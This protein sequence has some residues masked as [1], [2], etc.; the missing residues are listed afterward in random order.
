MPSPKLV[1]APDAVVAPVPPPRIETVPES[2]IVPELV[3]GPFSKTRPATVE[4]MSTLRTVPAP[5]FDQTGELVPS[6]TR[7]CPG[8]PTGVNA[9]CEPV[10]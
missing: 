2:V 7:I 5:T 10:E 4:D 6:E 1:L 9:N 3:I 8:E